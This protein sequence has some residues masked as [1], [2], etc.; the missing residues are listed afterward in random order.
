VTCDDIVPPEVLASILP[1]GELRPEAVDPRALLLEY[2]RLAKARAQIDDDTVA[3][4]EPLLGIPWLEAICGCRVMVAEGKSIWPEPPQEGSGSSDIV[5]SKDNAWFQKLLEAQSILSHHA[6]GRYAVSTSHMRGPTDLL[7]ALL[8]SDRFFLSLFD[9]PDHIERLARQASQ[10]WLE[11]VR[12]QMRIVPAFRGGYCVRQ[13]GLWA[14]ER[15]VWLQD[16]T[17]CMMSSNHYQR[18]FL[19]PLLSMSVVPYGV[20]HLH[21]PALHLAEMLASLRNVRAVNVYFDSPTTSLADA[22][23]TLRRLQSRHV[24]L[25]L[26]K[27]VDEGFSWEEYSEIVSQLSSAGLAVQLRADS[28]TEGRAVMEH[29]RGR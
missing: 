22:L 6:G 10:V 17:A 4:A 11:V 24:P 21:V 9:N 23:P 3:V 26:A 13:F 1:G 28:T 15:A 14:P 2:D 20:L 5:F 29:I 18:F 25:V 12:A 19:Q 27:T 7:V 16:D 8:G